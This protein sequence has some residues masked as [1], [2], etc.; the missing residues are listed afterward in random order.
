MSTNPSKRIELALAAN[1]GKI[2]ILVPAEVAEMT[3][4]LVVGLGRLV[5]EVEPIGIWAIV[6]VA[7]STETTASVEAAKQEQAEQLA[8]DAAPMTPTQILQNRE[9][10]RRDRK[11]ANRGAREH[12]RHQKRLQARRYRERGFTWS[13]TAEGLGVSVST[14]HRL[15]RELENLAVRV[16]CGDCGQE[17]LVVGASPL[18]YPLGVRACRTCAK[19]RRR[20]RK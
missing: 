2:G 13:Q 4:M 8:A 11:R 18:D 1:C 19:E 3:A 14:A 16:R 5:I 7:G 10:N 20:R 6:R 12:R 9:N 15:Y 17:R